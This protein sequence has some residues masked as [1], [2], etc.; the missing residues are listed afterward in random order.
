MLEILGHADG[1]FV[2]MQLLG[3]DVVGGWFVAVG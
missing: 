2:W 1:R 3:G